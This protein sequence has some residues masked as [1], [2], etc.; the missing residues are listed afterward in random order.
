M[1]R[2]HTIEEHEARLKAFYDT[3][4]RVPASKELG[5]A[6]QVA[7]LKKY[8]SWNG[9]T[10]GILG[11]SAIR[12]KWSDDEILLFLRSLYVKN[13]RLPRFEEVKSIKTSVCQFIHLR[14]GGLDSALEKAIGTSARREVLLALD[15]L[16]SG[17]HDYAFTKEIWDATNKKNISVTLTMVGTALARERKAGRVTGHQ[18]GVS[19]VWSLTP[20]GRSFLK[21]FRDGNPG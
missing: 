20:T 15:E 5:P 9:A 3:H 19:S 14:F 17:A 16:T 6:T 13:G 1:N 10:L 11:R 4:G 8:G 7:M 12:R 2:K 18:Y 21:S